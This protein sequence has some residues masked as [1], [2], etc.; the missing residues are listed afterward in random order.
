MTPLSVLAGAFLAIGCSTPRPTAAAAPGQTSQR[1]NKDPVGSIGRIEAGEGIVRV[2]ARGASGQPIVEHLLVK[3]GDVVQAGQLLAELDTKEQADAAVHQAAAQIEVA[4]RR[5]AQAQAGAKPSDIA[6]QQSEVERLQ[7]ELE[8]SQKEQQ[9]HLPLGNNV[10]ASE[11]DR[12]KLRV[13]ST[14]RSLAAAKQRLAGLSEVRSVDVDL[15]RAELEEAVRSEARAKAESKTSVITS[16]IDGR[17][18]KIDAWPGEAVGGDGLLELAPREPMYAIAEVAEFDIPRVKV[19]QRATVTGDGLNAPLH[20]TVERLSMRVLQNQLMRV[21]PANFSD[22]R[23][24]EVWVKLDEGERVADL[25][26]MRVDV[27]IQP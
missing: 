1:S 11:L 23:V 9:R 6:A 17:V 20:G 22:A 13:E 2:A 5:L 27:V 12:L 21:D 26:H 10:T 18:V 4:Q 3:Q 8:N 7:T 16:P 25:I 19:G 24:V 14:T 15:A